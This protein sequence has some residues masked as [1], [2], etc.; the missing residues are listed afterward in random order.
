MCL[1]F[2]SCLLRIGRSDSKGTHDGLFKFFLYCLFRL[3]R[4][5]YFAYP[6]SA[7]EVQDYH[8]VIKNPISFQTINEKL[9][10]HKYQSVDEFSVSYPCIY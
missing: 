1:A 5:K 6:I 7:E 4:Q 10:A 8:D 9:V 3:D 2:D